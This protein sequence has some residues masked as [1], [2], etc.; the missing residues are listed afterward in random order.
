[1]SSNDILLSAASLLL[2]ILTVVVGRYRGRIDFTQFMTPHPPP[3]PANGNGNG[4]YAELKARW[5]SLDERTKPIGIL[6][7]D[8]GRLHDD[9][10]MTKQQF[11]DFQRETNR[12][13]VTMQAQISRALEDVKPALDALPEI[14]QMLRHALEQRGV[15]P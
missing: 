14:Q 9:L 11:I 8:L 10:N 4:Q 7:E 5:D 2:S 12:Q 13:F 15:N 1:M 6:H 3:K